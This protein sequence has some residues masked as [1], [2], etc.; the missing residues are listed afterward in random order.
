MIDNLSQSIVNALT[1]GD[2]LTVNKLL[3]DND[4]AW[5]AESWID[6]SSELPFNLASIAFAIPKPTEGEHTYSSRSVNSLTS[7][8]IDLSG[9]RLPVEIIDTGIGDVYLSQENDEMFF[10]LIK[11]LRENAKIRVVTDLL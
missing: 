2:E 4:L 5:N 10:S 3:T 11:Q 6:R 1:S 8:V 9:V 7:L